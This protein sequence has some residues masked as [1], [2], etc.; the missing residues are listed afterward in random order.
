MSDLFDDLLALLEAHDPLAD[1]AADGRGVRVCVVDS[2]IDRAKLAHR[3]R[4]PVEG[5][6]FREDRP[7][8]LPDEGAPS[9]PHGTTVADILLGVAPGITLF[10]ADVF[11][12]TG[13]CDARVVIRAI[14]H[15]MD[16]WGC[17]VVNLS[18]G[19]PEPRLAVVQKRMELQRAVEEAYY[20][21]VVV[22]AA[23]SN[24]HPHT[25]SYPAA[26]APPLLS[27]D[28]G[29]FA[30]PAEFGYRLLEQVE[31]QAHAKGTLGPF[32]SQAATSWAAPHL[33]GIVARLL[34]LRPGLK[35]FEV[36]ALLYWLAQA[37]KRR[38]PLA[39]A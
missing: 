25:R 33:S 37:R 6:V 35:P 12:P 11:G 16:A 28:K 32:A 1:P 14:R 2:G 36:K 10:S 26:F 19:I 38:E 18:L 31:W 24:D 13:S 7:E 20:R 29:P 39:G 30:S 23:A 9:S 5:A 27:V 15:A 4:G 3:L 17:Q 21:G 34:S 8:P 22:V